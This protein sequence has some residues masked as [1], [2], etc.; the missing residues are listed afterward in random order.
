[1]KDLLK[2]VKPSLGE[3]FRMACGKRKHV[4]ECKFKL[5]SSRKLTVKKRK[6]SFQANRITIVSQYF[7]LLYGDTK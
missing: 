2:N 3:E 6:K 4:K 5:P 1:M 7:K